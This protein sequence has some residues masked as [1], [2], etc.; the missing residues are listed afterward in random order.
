MS[1][2]KEVKQGR[3]D[4]FVVRPQDITVDETYNVRKDYGDM[5]ELKR[6]IKAQGVKEALKVQQKDGKI[7]LVSGHRRLRAA[8]ELIKENNT[9]IN[10]PVIPVK[11]N[12]EEL[13]LDLISS[14]DGKNLNQIEQGEVFRRLENYGWK[15]K[16]IA[17]NTGR[18]IGHVSN[19]LAAFDLDPKIKEKVF[20]GVIKSS[21]AVELSRTHKNDPEAILKAIKQGEE[22]AQ[23]NGKE[24]VTK[25]AIEGK[26]RKPRAKKNTE[27]PPALTVELSPDEK[28]FICEFIN[29]ELDIDDIKRE[30]IVN[31]IKQYA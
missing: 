31:I 6:S 1:T 14:N 12:A 22:F 11:F 29:D 19:C 8:L 16:Q 28:D 17:E 26:E 21:L 7:I 4:K 3:G 13:A 18:T 2:L 25:K 24:S 20:K 5:S 27:T 23:V 9:Q 10:V 30:Y 15:Q